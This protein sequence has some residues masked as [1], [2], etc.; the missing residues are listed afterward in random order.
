[1]NECSQW[2]SV[3]D[4]KAEALGVHVNLIVGSRYDGEAKADSFIEPQDCN[5]EIVPKFPVF[6]LQ[7]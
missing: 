3:P 4:D 1:M 6:Q 7:H 5:M 2:M